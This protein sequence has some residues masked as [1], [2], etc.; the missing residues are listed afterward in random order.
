MAAR[1]T[2]PPVGPSGWRAAA[3]APTGAA[4]RRLRACL[5]MSRN[6]AVALAP[7]YTLIV[8]G[9][10]H[11]CGATEWAERCAKVAKLAQAPPPPPPMPGGRVDMRLACAAT[12]ATL[13]RPPRTRA[14]PV[15]DGRTLLF[16]LPRVQGLATNHCRDKWTDAQARLDA[17]FSALL[18]MC[19]NVFSFC[20]LP[21]AKA[22]APVAAPASV[23]DG[24]VLLPPSVARNLP[25]N[26]GAAA[27]RLS[28]QATE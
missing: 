2:G 28:A 8:G 3:G 24:R 10:G 21:A 13:T 4:S 27:V 17:V 9:A 1:T 25:I 16:S 15:P 19:E 26:R 6:F 5:A 7:N 20:L 18:T 23:R 12:Q 22:A 14:K 11:S